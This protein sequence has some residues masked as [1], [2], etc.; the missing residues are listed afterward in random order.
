ML[1]S[2]FLLPVVVRCLGLMLVFIMSM[3]RELVIWLKT[4][5]LCQSLRRLLLSDAVLDLHLLEVPTILD[6]HRAAT[7]LDASALRRKKI[8]KKN[9][10][11]DALLLGS[12]PLPD[13]ARTSQS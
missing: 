10:L 2:R 7:I 9:L 3:V 6:H 8:L 12:N 11:A 5:M 4:M 13:S 1:D